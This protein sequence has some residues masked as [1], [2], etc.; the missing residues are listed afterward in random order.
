V[1]KGHCVLHRPLASDDLILSSTIVT[2]KSKK[3]SAGSGVLAIIQ[4]ND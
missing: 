4:V 1:I 2:R 3:Y